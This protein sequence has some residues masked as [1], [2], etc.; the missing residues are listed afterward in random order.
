MGGNYSKDIYKQLMEIM[1][2]CDSLEKDLKSVKS[3]SKTQIH[4]LNSE[5]K[6]LD[7]KCNKLE[8]ENASL[9]QEVD[10]LT[11]ENSSLKKENSL[12]KEEIIHLNSVADNNSNN[13]SLPPSSDE[14]PSGK[15]AN[16]YNGR[17][18]S[19]KKSGGQ[20]GHPGT[21]LS[22][23]KIE[24]KIQSGSL[25]HAVENWVNG[26]PVYDARAIPDTDYISHY[27]IDLEIRP[28][29]KELRFYADPEGNHHIPR[30]Y[31]GEVVYGDTVKI[32][33]VD[34]YSE[35][36]ISL[37]R[38]QKLISSLS[39]QAIEIS[40]GSIFHFLK[41]FAVMGE[42]SLKQIERE[43]LREKVLCTDATYTSTD[44]VRSYIRN[45]TSDHAVRFCPMDSK[46]IEA[47]E[48]I[49]L[50]NRY[51]GILMHDHETAMYHFG[52]GHAECNIHLLRYL[53]KNAEDTGNAWSTDM[54]R[55]LTDANN[56]RKELLER[57]EFFTGEEAARITDEFKDLLIKGYEQN[58]KTQHKYAAS[59]E[60]TLL[61]RLTKYQVNHLL[62]LYDENV[63]FHNNDS[64]RDLRK[65]KTHQKMS[66]G[67]RKE[68]GSK[69]YCDIMSIVE[70]CKKKGM[71]VYENIGSIFAGKRAIF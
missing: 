70:T 58:E 8:D 5:I 9:R 54:I 50:L 25:E 59:E 46:T 21:M 49:G 34:L 3:S 24:E 26:I 17:T 69:L 16:E 35:G 57:Q 31:L 28:I 6:R 36:N 4:S 18:S 67:F 33:A 71:Q 37:E 63:K 30:K 2:R 51:D 52:S 65:C 43:L 68:S 19:G 13:S 10:A 7:S 44:G 22:K 39:G 42:Q 40:Q 45:F 11:K 27:A 14:K 12:L 15:K 47:H 55:L 61:N 23:K 41:Q 60:R 53:R 66:G 62:F 56:R 29:A 32:L 1:E 20:K 38:I 64:E 48:G